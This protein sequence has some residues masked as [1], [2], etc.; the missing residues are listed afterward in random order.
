MLIDKKKMQ[1]KAAEIIESASDKNV[2]VVQAIEQIVEDMNAGLI[3]QIKA[4]A[5]LANADAEYKKQ[6]GLR[7][8]NQK[9][10]DFYNMLKK[11]PAA[12]KQAITASQE[13]IIPTTVINRAMN[14]IHAKSS[15]MD[16][17]DFAPAGV[18]K[19]LFGSHSGTAVWGALTAVISA[20][21]ELSATITPANM[22]AY[23]LTVFMVIPKGIRDLANEWVDRY[24]SAVL[25]EAMQ[26]GAEAGYIAG[27]GAN[28]P[29]G[30]LYSITNNASSGN[31]KAAKTVLSNITELSP[32]GL[33][34][35][36]KTLTNGGKR[37]ASVMA[38]ICNPSDRVEYVDPAM[39]AQNAMGAYVN[40][41]GLNITV[42]ESV[43]CPAGTA[44]L[45]L[46]K[47][48]TMGFSGIKVD[49]YDQ[50]KAMDDADLI[51][52]KLYANGRADDDN[53]AVPFDVTQ[54]T[55]KLIKVKH[56]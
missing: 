32:K 1:Q 14:D 53:C 37:S 29:I 27:D 9:E 17:V 26:D 5:A 36:R 45:T 23:K 31:G 54:L 11:G 44:I 34:A 16:L 49:E 46:P 19:W 24:F 41:T 7:T 38:L 55:E 43:S 39:L 40:G 28:A 22:D 21:A 8:L 48:Y 10:H 4:E 51:I 12:I 52:G 6:L 2:G 3:E 13:D 18:T 30:L 25:T 20:S 56:V 47:V 50:T 35:A 33:A 15:V 42:Y